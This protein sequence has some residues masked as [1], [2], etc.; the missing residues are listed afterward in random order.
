MLASRS[1]LRH[2]P[3]PI[4]AHA[5]LISSHTHIPCIS[6]LPAVTNISQT[7][8]L[9]RTIRPAG[10][11]PSKALRPFRAYKDQ[12]NSSV[13]TIPE[14]SEDDIITDT[15]P[16][17]SVLGQPALIIGRQMEM[18]N[19]FLGFE[20]ASKFVMQDVNGN[21]I[22]Y[23]AEE[24]GGFGK[25]IQRQLLRTHRPFTATILDKDGEI[26]LR[27]QRA[28]SIINSVIKIEDPNGEVIGEVHQVW[29]PWRRKYNL[30]IDKMQFAKVDSGFLA[31]DFDVLDEQ[32]SLVGN[33]SRNFGGFARE[34]FTDTGTYV[35]RMDG[36]EGGASRPLSLDERAVVLALAVTIDVD[37]FSRHSQ[38]GGHGL[39]PFL[40]FG[41][42][43]GDE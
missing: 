41:F 42:G 29:H 12:L 36:V 39:F 26:V 30:F 20:Q 27:I 13:V 9:R 3:R 34:I 21:Q 23:V 33:V 15:S 32:Y 35:L 40:P 37:Y 24:D 11:R 43:G 14:E 28:F 10:P 7:R 17:A 2:T 5:T 22:G 8:G 6:N 4:V 16:A 31:W 19:V 1:L 38:P 18:M 25:A